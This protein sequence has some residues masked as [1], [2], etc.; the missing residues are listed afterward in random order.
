MKAVLE[1]HS[2]ML[3]LVEHLP[4]LTSSDLKTGAQ[5]RLDE[6]VEHYGNEHWKKYLHTVVGTQAVAL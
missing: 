2:E 6:G 1:K 4:H 3:G 5:V